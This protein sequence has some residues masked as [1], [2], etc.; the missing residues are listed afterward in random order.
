[1]AKA[2]APGLLHKSDVGGVAIDLRSANDLAAAVARMRERIP[3][4]TGI[5]LQRYVAGG[6]EAL[7]GVAN[8]SI[9][10]PLIV[11]GLGGVL[12]ELL[13]D[14]AYRLP[15]VTDVDANDMLD[16]L[17]LA[18][19]LAGYRG[20]PPGDRAALSD[21]IQRVSALVEVVPEVVAL[22]LNPI[23]VLTPGEGV[24]VVDARLQLAR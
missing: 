13:H 2:I 18:P 3:Q 9:F 10:G 8:D 12:V 11:C 21:L 23:K 15:P 4:L 17:R 16:A 24:T 1:V 5:L 7:V 22:D 19:L 6:I 20:A 14:V